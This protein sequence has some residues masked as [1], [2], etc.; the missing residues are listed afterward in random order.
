M[1]YA[2]ASAASQAAH[3]PRPLVLGVS[4]A[5]VK[6][7]GGRCGAGADDTLLLAHQKVERMQEAHGSGAVSPAAERCYTQRWKMDF[8]YTRT[9]IFYSMLA[10][11]VGFSFAVS[12]FN[13]TVQHTANF[14]ALVQSAN[15]VKFSMRE[16]VFVR[17]QQSAQ[18]SGHVCQQR[19]K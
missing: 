14:N 10:S 11:M 12:G 16:Q 4:V 5:Q 1:H 17:V 3:R 2:A 6:M 18:Y 19:Y 7:V 13:C 15:C 8:L 9:C